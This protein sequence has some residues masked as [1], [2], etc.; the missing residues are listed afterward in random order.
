MEMIAAL[1][2]FQGLAQSTRLEIFRLL[3]KAGASGLAAGVIAQRL[4][5]PPSTL[6]FHLN[7]LSE[8]RLINAKKLGKFFFYS[9]N[10]TQ[11]EALLNFLLENCCDGEGC[12]TIAKSKDSSQ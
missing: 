11:T 3:V 8:A 2:C 12:I 6:S 4:N 10:Y 5:C 1:K 9:V 7:A